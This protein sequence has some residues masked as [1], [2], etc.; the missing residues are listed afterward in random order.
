LPRPTP[1]G[2]PTSAPPRRLRRKRP[3]LTRVF[4]GRRYDDE[5]VVYRHSNLVY[6]WPVWLLG[7]IA[8]VATYFGDR[9]MAIV[10]AGTQAAEH[11]QVDVPGE[12]LQ[13]RDVLILGTGKKLPTRNVE[14]NVQIV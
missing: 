4:T 10:P 7:Y 9:H 14:G 12:G 3:W 8:A 1:L 6:W 13:E 11:R 2:T 5:V